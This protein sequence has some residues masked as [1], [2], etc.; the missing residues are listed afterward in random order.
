MEAQMKEAEA[1]Q[2]RMMSKYQNDTQIAES[3]VILIFFYLKTF[4][5]DFS[6]ISFYQF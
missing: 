3:K 6:H 2:E 1:E 5:S 4:I